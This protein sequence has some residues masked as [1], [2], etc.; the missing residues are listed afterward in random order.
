MFVTVNI[1]DH[2][3]TTVCN[4]VFMQHYVFSFIHNSGCTYT[5]SPDPYYLAS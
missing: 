1:K 2:W 3:K 4:R 5:L